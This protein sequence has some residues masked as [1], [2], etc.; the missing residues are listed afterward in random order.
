MG[1]AAA[2]AAVNR[3]RPTQNMR[4]RPKRSPSAAPV[5]SRQANATW[6]AFTV[7][8][9]LE[10]LAPRSTRR[11]GRAVVTTSVSSAVMKT[12]SEARTIVQTLCDDCC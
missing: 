5:R 1:A 8:S 2:E 9:R 11:T 7:H 3:A 4:R 6:Y 12:P 10:R